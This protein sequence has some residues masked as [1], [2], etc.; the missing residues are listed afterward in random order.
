M[1]RIST[2]ETLEV[3]TLIGKNSDN[4]YLRVFEKFDGE[5]QMR[6]SFVAHWDG[7]DF[8]LLRDFDFQIADLELLAD[9]TLVVLAST[10]ELFS[11]VDGAWDNLAGPLEPVGRVT[12]LRILP[13]GIFA[14][15]KGLVY[16]LDG[17]NWTARESSY[18]RAMIF[19]MIEERD[20]SLLIC[21]Q[22][23]AAARLLVDGTVTQLELPT[24][25]NLTNIHQDSSGTL[26]C[27]AKSTLIQLL[28]DEVAIFTDA[29]GPRNFYR[30]CVFEGRVLLSAMSA[31]LEFGAD[32]L[33][34][35]WPNQSFALISIGDRLFNRA[36]T[37]IEVLKEGVWEDFPVWLDLPDVSTAQSQPR[38]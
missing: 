20:G 19:D 9:G 24:N 4:L 3:G 13:S 29:A 27:G 8:H 30:F 1:A 18:Q 34:E 2:P 31:I 11:Y 12:Q 35:A 17:T 36:L 38:R 14:L 23:G 7:S 32:G 33:E 22:R 16:Q 5:A 10:G 21:G 37:K 28:D 15:G 6:R 25:A 26:F